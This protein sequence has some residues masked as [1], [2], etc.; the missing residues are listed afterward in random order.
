[1]GNALSL[2]ILNQ[3]D[4]ETV[5]DG[6]PA[7]LLLADSFIE[8][9]PRDPSMLA[10]GAKLYAVY[11]ALFAPSADRATRLAERA[12]QY[13][14]RALCASLPT[15]CDLSAMHH[16]EFERQL[17]KAEVNAVPALNAF[18]VG[19]LAW[20]QARRGDWNALADLPR[21][22]S[23]LERIVALNERY[24]NGSPHVYLGILHTL[25]PP[26]LGGHPELGRK[27]FERAIEISKG[28][29]LGA[30]VAFAAG[31]ARLMYDRE[32]HDRLIAEVLAADPR[33]KGLTLLNTMAIRRARQLAATADSHF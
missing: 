24:D 5:R 16:E 29:D 4:P 17:A 18:V 19:N 2:A 12:R 1:M 23:A 6:A 14:N 13:G 20:I 7:F 21:L 11:S 33:E 9:S 27:H 26:S 8:A 15:L 22:Q 10:A 32:L 25:R 30:K 28:R 31:Y 3:D